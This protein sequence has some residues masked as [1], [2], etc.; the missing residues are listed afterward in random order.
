MEKKVGTDRG[1][2]GEAI[3]RWRI[4]WSKEGKWP[5]KKE[6]QEM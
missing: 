4:E 5:R 1:R 6:V 3:E 2:G